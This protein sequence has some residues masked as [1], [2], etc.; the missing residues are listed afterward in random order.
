MPR[1]AI[2]NYFFSPLV[3]KPGDNSFLSFDTET[4]GDKNKYYICGFYDGKNY[5]YTYDKVEA[6]KILLDK[7]DKG[8]RVANN[9]GFDLSVVF[10]IEGLS[11]FKNSVSGSDIILSDKD[12]VKFR[13]AMN[14]GHFSVKKQGQI[15][16]IPKLNKPTF[17][18]EKPKNKH[19]DKILIEY[20]KFDC[21]ITY[22]YMM[23]WLNEL[24]NMRGNL[25][26]TIASTSMDYYRRKHL[27]ESIKN[28]YPKRLRNY[29]FDA[30]Y[31]GRVEAYKRGRI[32][33][34]FVSDYNSLYPAMMLNEYPKPNKYKYLRYPDKTIINNEGVSHV[35]I[36]IPK[37]DKPLL[38]F[39]DKKLIFPVGTFT[40]KYSNLELREA[41]N[42]GATIKNIYSSLIYT[43][44]HSPFRSFVEDLYSK[45]EIYKKNNSPLQIIYKI[46]LNSLYGKF[47]QRRGFTLESFKAEPDAYYGDDTYIDDDSLFAYTKTDSYKNA[48]YVFPIY[49]LYVTAYGRLKL[50]EEMI[51]HDA[52]YV[53]TDSIFS[54]HEIED[55]DK[56]GRLKTEFH[57]K[58]GV[59]IKPKLYLIRNDD[60]VKVKA[61]GF[62]HMDADGFKSLLRGESHSY[63]KFAKL[64]E[65]IRRKIP[66][67]YKMIIKKYAK[68]EDDK[69]Y[70]HTKFNPGTL[71]EDSEPWEL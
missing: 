21:I 69:R 56:L 17:L 67:N 71:Q 15:L 58:D 29:L 64:R 34:I 50:H 16:G 24:R 25:K 48:S 10:G 66:V 1:P 20:N 38:P 57:I 65:S 68:L 7:Q 33:N 45:R 31:G 26:G 53:D 28:D 62:T 51:K 55:S 14:F 70:W 3:K 59:I 9:L 37:T 6:Q 12:G 47:G 54:K 60:E 36:S 49:S 43:E 32:K 39:R 44:T 18:G 61:K 63:M 46:M 5:Y 41:V 23:F 13:D 35:K 11:G 8:I 2:K 19:Q 27:K 22:E 40:G 42:Q 52:Y 30:Y 4:Y